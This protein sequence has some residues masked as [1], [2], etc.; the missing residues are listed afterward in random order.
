MPNKPASLY[1]VG[2]GPGSAAFLTSQAAQALRNAQCIAGYELYLDLLGP[3]FKAGKKLMATG[4]RR[5][6][7]RC[8]KAIETAL[9]GCSTAIISSGDAGIYA[10]ASLTLELLEQ[11][12]LLQTVP[13][14]IIAGVPALCA[15]AAR[16]GAPIGHDFACI[17]LS[18]LLTPREIINK[19]LHACFEADF[20]CILYNPRSHGRPDYLTQA[21]AIAQEYRS[22]VC[23]VALCRNI[24]RKGEQALVTELSRFDPVLADMLSII[25]IGNS[26]S[27]HIGGWMLTPRGY[28]GK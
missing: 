27:R 3:E 21:L 13:F 17:S 23:P 10:M 18:D 19:R 15:A 22:P 28:S 12:N 2:I 16:V 4:M 24:G 25:I 14:E 11:L 6:R 1:I 20:V 5:E 9:A 26:E 7:E 8:L